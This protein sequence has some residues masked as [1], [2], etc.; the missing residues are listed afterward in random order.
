MKSLEFPEMMT[1]TITFPPEK[2]RAQTSER[3]R[4]GM[5][6]IDS[7]AL[8]NCPDQL[9]WVTSGETKAWLKEGAATVSDWLSI[10]APGLNWRAV[11][12]ELVGP[13]DWD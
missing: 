1:S 9:P 2:R 8:R 4:S 3:D 7:R 12:S 10:M 11:C 6:C 13:Q 5:G